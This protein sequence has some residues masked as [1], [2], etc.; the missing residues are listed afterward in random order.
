MLDNAVF[1][2]ALLTVNRNDVSLFLEW[3]EVLGTMVRQEV[4]LMGKREIFA[5]LFA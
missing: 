3:Q 2:L 4:G 1:K 5:S